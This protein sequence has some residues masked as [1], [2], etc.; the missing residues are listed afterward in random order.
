MAGW[1]ETGELESATLELLLFI[2]V[3]V[4]PPPAAKDEND[5][6]EENDDDSSWSLHRLT[7][8]ALSRLSNMTCGGQLQADVHLVALR[9]G[10]GFQAK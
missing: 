2:V 3:N 4:P 1:L 8:Q 9:C 6:N 5:E 10:C 7:I